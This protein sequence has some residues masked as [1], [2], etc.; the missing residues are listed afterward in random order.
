MVIARD[1]TKKDIYHNMVGMNEIPGG[2]VEITTDYYSTDN[3]TP[4]FLLCVVST[5]N[6]V[7]SELSFLFLGNHKMTMLSV[8][9]NMKCYLIS[10]NIET[11][12]HRTSFNWYAYT[13][14]PTCA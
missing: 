3:E 4:Y 7:P 6:I 14:F 9:Q 5:S 11:C 10:S 12:K 1:T 8:R 13:K 2:I